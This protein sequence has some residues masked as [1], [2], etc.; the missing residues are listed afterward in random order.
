MLLYPLA[1]FPLAAAVMPPH[2]AYGGAE[3]SRLAEEGVSPE[4]GA[5]HRLEKPEA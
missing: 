3:L 1:T 4:G 2:R 5:A